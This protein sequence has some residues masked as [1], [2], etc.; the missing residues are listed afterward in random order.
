MRAPPRRDRHHSIGHWTGATKSSDVTLRTA[1]ITTSS[2]RYAFLLRRNVG[3]APPASFTSAERHRSPRQGHLP[4][5]ISLLTRI[6]Q[7]DEDTS[8]YVSYTCMMHELGL[9]ASFEALTLLWLVL[10]Q[11][12]SARCGDRLTAAHV[13]GMQ[14][15]RSLEHLR[16]IRGSF[17][18][19]CPLFAS[20]HVLLPV[21]RSFC[22]L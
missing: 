16:P 13:P 3:R 7:D 6:S 10:I 11:M 19:A 21:T 9:C 2:E 22:L 15:M 14:Q 18:G 17:G 5:T 1:G 8:A 20:V 4:L 12:Y